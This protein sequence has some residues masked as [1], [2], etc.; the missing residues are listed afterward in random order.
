MREKEESK[1]K[2]RDH[3]EGHEEREFKSCLSQKKVTQGLKS[4]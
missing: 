4:D 2:S 3:G 1:N